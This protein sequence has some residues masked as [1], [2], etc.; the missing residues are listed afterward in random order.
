[1]MTYGVAFCREDL[2]ST[3]DKS[4]DDLFARMIWVFVG[5]GDDRRHA[6]CLTLECRHAQPSIEHRWGDIVTTAVMGHLY[7]LESW[8]PQPSPGVVCC[9]F[10]TDRPS[11]SGENDPTA[12]EFGQLHD[13]AFV[14]W[15][16]LDALL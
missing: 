5:R 13:T 11:V 9:L 6:A 8:H 2:A 15:T 4:V 16:G 14:R 7:Q 10:E 3:A 1:M 12:I